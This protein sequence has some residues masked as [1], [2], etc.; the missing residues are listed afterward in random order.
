MITREE[1]EVWEIDFV[2]CVVHS[3]SQNDKEAA[4]ATRVGVE[5][6]LIWGQWWLG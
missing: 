2:A 1:A 6:W 3:T 4:G 5:T